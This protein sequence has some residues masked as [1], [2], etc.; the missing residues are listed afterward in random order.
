MK[1][2]S[3]PA[4][5]F[6]CLWAL[7]VLFHMEFGQ[8]WWHGGTELGSSLIC[9]CA[10]LIVLIVPWST[11]AFAT[12]LITQICDVY[13]ILP[14]C[15]NHWMLMG[16]TNLVL[17]IGIGWQALSQRCWPSLQVV[18][19]SARKPLQI[20][21]VLFYWWAVFWKLNVDFLRP[22]TSCA[23]LFSEGILNNLLP[24]LVHPVGVV[25]PVL[26]LVFE[27]LF[28]VAL[29]TKRWRYHGLV[30]LVLFHCMLGLHINHLLLN[31]SSVM[32][33]LLTLFST[34]NEPED[35]APDRER[36]WRLAVV[37]AW[38]FLVLGSLIIV[39]WRLEVHLYGRFFLWI[40][41][42][43]WMIL[44]SLR[45][46]AGLQRAAKSPRGPV[47]WLLPALIMLNGF[48]PI[49]GLK[50]G[51]S[52]QMYSNLSLS[53]TDSNHLI[54]PRSAD[55]M[56]W[57]SD[58]II[59]EDSS[60]PELKQYFTTGNP[61]LATYTTLRENPE[62][63]Q[64]PVVFVRTLVHRVPGATLSYRYRDQVVRDRP[65]ESDPLFA[66]PNPIWVEKLARFPALGASGTNNCTW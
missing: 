2:A 17:L 5:N 57:L 31:F 27:G 53:A 34:D 56:G 7:A 8:L 39:P 46:R 30:G 47:Y 36:P 14:Q 15:P 35:Y 11:L 24:V 3:L 50:T 23:Y 21:T 44:G 54:L 28:P 1:S 48:T 59:I 18:I 51:T 45:A 19:N 63:L 55:A 26:T 62:P 65:W 6:P 40:A 37:F 29:L 49:I 10:A 20:A 58:T 43:S 12:M 41:P 42:A 32:F 52:W 61:W 22:S 38:I 33:G 64:W 16:L 60:N 25:S 9:T 13:L 66:Q 4:L